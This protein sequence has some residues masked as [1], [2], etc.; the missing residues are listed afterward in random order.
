MANLNTAEDWRTFR[1]KALGSEEWSCFNSVKMFG[2]IAKPSEGMK[3]VE[4]LIRD[5]EPLV[6]PRL[7]QVYFVIQVGIFAIS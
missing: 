7:L 3:S 1:L 5:G 6:S 4:N 2:W